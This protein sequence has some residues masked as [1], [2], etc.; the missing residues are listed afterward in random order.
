ML[1]L[2]HDRARITAFDTQIL[3]LER[4]GESLQTLRAARDA[5]QARLD[6][7]KYPVLTLPNEVVC[8]IFTQFLPTYPLRPPLVGPE[9]P[10]LLTQICHL[11]REIA[12]GM[13]TLWRA[14]EL[15]YSFPSISVQAYICAVTSSGILEPYPSRRKSGSSRARVARAAVY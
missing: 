3:E 13:P 12:I 4:S 6:A 2:D 7:F 14:I 15:C 8:E 9:S 10:T 11:W 5:V 1:I